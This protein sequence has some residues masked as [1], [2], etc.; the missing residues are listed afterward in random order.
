VEKKGS[1]WSTSSP[2]KYAPRS[3]KCL[4]IFILLILLVRPFLILQDLCLIRDRTVKSR[5]VHLGGYGGGSN[6]SVPHKK[7]SRRKKDPKLPLSACH[8]SK[9]VAV[10]CDASQQYEA[11]SPKKDVV[12]ASFEI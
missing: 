2:R 7:G 12:L 8:A 3:Q 5:I 4:L 1:F 6:G 9:S 11:P 10:V